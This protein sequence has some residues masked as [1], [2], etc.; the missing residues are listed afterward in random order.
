MCEL[1]IPHYTS[2]IIFAVTK[3]VPQ[4]VFQQHLLAYSTFAFGFAV[5]A[6]GRGALFSVIN[7]KLSQALRWGWLVG[8]WVG[9]SEGWYAVCCA[10]Y[11][12]V[13][14]V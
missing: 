4:Q 10:L 13:Q 8:G 3:Q 12:M 11:R 7:N 9:G 14:L 5:F 6:A 1:M 2:K